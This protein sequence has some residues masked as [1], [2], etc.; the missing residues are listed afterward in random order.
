LVG[1]IS[2]DVKELLIQIAQENEFTI[3]Q[4]EVIPDHVHLFVTATPNHLIARMIKA[5]KG[6]DT[7]GIL[8]T[9]LGRWDG[10]T[11]LGGNR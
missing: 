3:G 2:D 8:R 11:Y 9:T 4:M 6:V 10:G 5:L 1:Q 7:S